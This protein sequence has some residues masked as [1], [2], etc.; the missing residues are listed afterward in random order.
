MRWGR[1]TTGSATGLDLVVV[2]HDATNTLR[3]ITNVTLSINNPVNT[4]TFSVAATQG[5]YIALQGNPSMVEIG[6]L[7]GDGYGDLVIPMRSTN[8]STSGVQ[9]TTIG[10]YYTCLSTGTGACSVSGWG[11][12]G[13]QGSSVSVGDVTSD[14]YPE[15]FVGF[16]S[17]TTRL[18]YRNI[19]RVL[20]ISY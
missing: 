9:G 10:V 16:G 1:I 12:E 13:A 5:S 14:G 11:L 20:N 7:N 19:S 4:G 6:D 15:L 3:I 17:T 18:L 8:A 2:G